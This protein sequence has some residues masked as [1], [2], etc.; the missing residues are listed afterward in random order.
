MEQ[1]MLVANA[2]RIFFVAIL[3]GSVIRADAQEV[4]AKTD[5]LTWRG[6]NLN[7]IAASGQTPVASWTDTKNVV[8]KTPVPGRG[9]ASPTIVGNKIFLATCDEASQTQSV[10]AF[11]RASGRQLWKQDLNRGGLP[12]TI[13]KKNTHATP[14]VASDGRSLFVS[15]YNHDGIQVSAL[16]LDGKGLWQ[17]VVGPFLPRQYKYG[18]AASPMLYKSS[19][20]VVGDYDGDAWLAALDSRTGRTSWKIKRPGKLSWSSPVV[21]NIAGRDQ[22]LLSGNDMVASYDPG[23]GRQLWST[24]ATTM[25]TCGT[26]IWEGDLVF[27]SG[28]YPKSET[29]C[30][31]A[32][33]SGKIVWKNNHKCYEQSMLVHEG[34]VYAVTD[35]GIAFCWRAKD[36]QE[37]W[38]DR[39]PGGPVSASPILAGGNIY[40][41]NE[42]GTTYVFTA[43]PRKF[44]LV[45]Q[46]QL[47]QEAFAT[48]TICGSRIFLRVADHSSGRREFLY[49]IG[50]G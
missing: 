15:F 11:D 33:G 45:G 48:P 39:L 22:L 8:W 35:R 1:A 36:G 26:M 24:A 2:K 43:I 3:L 10:V 44:E 50:G 14:T 25:A 30:I 27:A 41:S 42:R 40:L 37:M 46:T 12:K 18:Y 13:H 23:S 28:G 20:L 16:S 32:D 17:Q 19:V 29:V 7:G 9:H 5:W 31:R 34:H 4:G 21:A 47:G 38:T 6:P 49:C